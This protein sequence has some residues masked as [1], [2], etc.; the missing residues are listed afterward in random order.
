M[1]SNP[2][3]PRGVNT[4]VTTT[5]TDLAVV[6]H[7][8]ECWIRPRLGDPGARV[9]AV[10]KPSESGMSSVSV[11]FTVDWREGGAPHRADLVA[12]LVPEDTA[13]PV[14]PD[15][16]LEHQA[17]VM[18]AVA[19]HGTVPVPRVRWVETAADVLGRPF[20]VMDRVD[21]VVPV[22]NPPYVFG[23]WLCDATPEQADI[24]QR[25]SVDVLARIHALPIPDGMRPAHTSAA[26]LLRR[27]VAD[28][29][30]YYDWTRREDGMRIPVLERGFD[31][32]E[33]N[34]PE[35]PSEPVLCW[36]DSRIGNILYDDFRP[37]AVLDWELATV[38]PRELDVGWFV[39]FHRMFQDMAEQFDRP[40]L[41]ALFRR[42]DVV[43]RYRETAGVELRDL[44]FYLVYAAVRHGAIMSRIKRRSIHFGDS[45]IPEDPD[46]YVLHH[47]MLDRMIDDEYLWEAQ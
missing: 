3:P 5:V 25:S 22:D 17:A 23:G 9:S 46:H 11:L 10:R 39:F 26:T 32:L 45:P 6:Q 7:R 16:D 28:T 29:R 12:R 24:L 8:L 27:H 43:A 21:G 18:R 37:A 30:A 47:R 1:T 44:D 15:Y 38:A 33:R 35:H 14:F 31:W 34:R 42:A 20:V 40:G 41:P 13:L 19:A 36:G 4:A 2:A